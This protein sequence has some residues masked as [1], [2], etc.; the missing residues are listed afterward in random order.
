MF[1][2]HCC[3]IFNTSVWLV[4]LILILELLHRLDRILAEPESQIQ[5]TSQSK[6]VG[7]STSVKL[8]EC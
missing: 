2:Y 5:G 7:R 6:R 8:C 3:T 1:V 4:Q